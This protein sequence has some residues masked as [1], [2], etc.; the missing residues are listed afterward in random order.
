MKKETRYFFF[1]KKFMHITFC[2]KTIKHDWLSVI[3]FSEEKCPENL[4]FSILIK[5][6]PFLIIPNAI[7]AEIILS[8]Y[9]IAQSNKIV[10][11]RFD[12]ILKNDEP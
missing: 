3:R 8:H 6:F 1:L 11:G 12:L 9:L 7:S 2:T 4:S 5:H 10:C